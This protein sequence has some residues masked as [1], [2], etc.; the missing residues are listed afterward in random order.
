MNKKQRTC[1]NCSH[2]S[3]NFHPV[4]KYWCSEDCA[5]WAKKPSDFGCK[6]HIFKDIRHEKKYG[7]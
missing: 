3:K 6:K 5:A 4:W 7:K 1:A 2:L